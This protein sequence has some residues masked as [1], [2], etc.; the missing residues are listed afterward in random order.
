[1]TRL[2]DAEVVKGWRDDLHDRELEIDALTIRATELRGQLFAAHILGF[3]Q[4]AP[5]NDNERKYYAVLS[6]LLHGILVKAT[7]SEPR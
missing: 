5:A 1:M 3:Q 4:A 7:T 6:K 2:L